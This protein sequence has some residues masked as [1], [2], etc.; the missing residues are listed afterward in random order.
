MFH[1]QLIESRPLPCAANKIK[2]QRKASKRLHR[3]KFAL[4]AACK[5]IKARV[6]NEPPR[7]NKYLYPNTAHACGVKSS[8]TN[9][10]STCY[11]ELKAFRFLSPTSSTA[12]RFQIAHWRKLQQTFFY[13]LNDFQGI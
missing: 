12:A 9:R 11:Q 8:L 7:V 2:R 6:A 3:N 10:L 1:A 13:F 5:I 4:F